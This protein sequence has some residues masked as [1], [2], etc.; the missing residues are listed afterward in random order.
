MRNSAVTEACACAGVEWVAIGT[1]SKKAASAAL[2]AQPQMRAANARKAMAFPLCLGVGSLPPRKPTRPGRAEF[3]GLGMF[4]CSC[5]MESSAKSPQFEAKDGPCDGPRWDRLGEG[6]SGQRRMG[7]NSNCGCR[8]ESV[9]AESDRLGCR[10]RCAD[11]RLAAACRRA[12][13]GRVVG[14][15]RR[16]L[17]QGG[18]LV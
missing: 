13:R 4:P 7:S 17:R 16:E 12:Q 8:N 11:R 2:N 6:S 5:R 3:P 18:K 14:A 15:G 1:A 9:V 10:L